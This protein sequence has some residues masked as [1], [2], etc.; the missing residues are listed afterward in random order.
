LLKLEGEEVEQ[1]A[2]QPG[3][4]IREMLEE[5]GWTQTDFARILDRPIP[6]VNE[7]IQG[8]RAIMPEMAMALAA[9]LGRDARFWLSLEANRQLAFAEDPGGD[10]RKRAALFEM[11]PIKDMEKRGW[12][13]RTTTAAELEGELRRFFGCDDLSQSPPLL[14]STRRTAGPDDLTPVQRAWCFRARNLASSQ[15][16]APFNADAMNDCAAALRKLAAFAPEAR[17][18]AR[19][20]NEYGIRFVIVEPLSGAKIDGA[21][22]WLGDDQPAIALS[23]RHDRI[24]GFWHT[25]CHELSHIRHRD[26]LSIDSALV[27]EDAAPSA[28][29]D[30]F[31]RRADK[32]AAEML[33]PADKLQSFIRRVA[34]LYS[35]D[36]IV[37]FAHR[38]KIHPGI[39]VGQLQHRGEIGFHANRELL[40][41]VRDTVTSVGIVDGWGHT[42]A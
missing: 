32:D 17:K 15:V 6:T 42:T 40:A 25:L 12:I 39:I 1:D 3:Q 8:K 2:K 30:S 23:L 24:D 16:V 38:V 7:I 18:V 19:L 35:R 5:R 28:V 29:K 36:R 21:A 41:K 4:V 33:I 31:E 10:V 34:P 37:Q 26:A 13:N 9:A 11:A 14:L 27:G 22:F 20:L